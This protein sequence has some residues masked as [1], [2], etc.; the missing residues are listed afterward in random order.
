MRKRPA[1]LIFLYHARD[2]M[3]LIPAVGVGVVEL[4]TERGLESINVE[5]DEDAM[6]VVSYV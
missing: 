1:Y 4:E 2:G 6:A 5:L 3:L